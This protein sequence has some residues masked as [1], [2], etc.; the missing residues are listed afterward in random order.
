MKTGKLGNK[1]FMPLKKSGNK[2]FYRLGN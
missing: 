2:E 1:E